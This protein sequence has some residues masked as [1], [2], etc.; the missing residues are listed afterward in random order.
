MKAKLQDI[1]REYGAE[2]LLESQVQADP[3]IQFQ[4]WFN[5][6]LQAGIE[7]PSAMV[8]ATVDAQG[9]P[10]S[11]IVLLKE[12]E[13]GDFHFYSSYRGQKAQQLEQNPYAALNFYWPALARQVRIRGKITQLSR[14]Q[15]EAYFASRPRDSQLAAHVAPQSSS[16]KDRQTLEDRLTQL[17]KQFDKQ[18]VP[19]PLTWGG[20]RL[21]PFEYEFFQGRDGRLHDRLRYTLQSTH[22]WK[23]ERLAP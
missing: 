15:S 12:L 11:R 18:P 23:I 4:H 16:V 6:V 13:A 3:F 8:L 9:I 1:R 10:D 22:T 14:P 7:D 19:C 5:Q 21:T 17:A 20:Y 2:P